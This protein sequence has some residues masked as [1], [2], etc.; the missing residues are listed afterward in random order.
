MKIFINCA[1]GLG[2]ITMFLPAY[3]A[4]RKKYPAANYTIA[5]DSRFYNDPF[6]KQ[7]FGKDCNIIKIYSKEEGYLKFLFSFIKLIRFRFDISI[8]AYNGNS[9]FNG[10]CL[11]LVGAKKT[12]YIQTTNK[13]LNRLFSSSLQIPAT[14]KH[15]I[16]INFLV[17]RELGVEIDVPEKWLLLENNRIIKGIN[18]DTILIGVHPGGNI[19]F[20]SARQW[21]KEY[22]KKLIEDLLSVYEAKIVI[23]GKGDLEDNMI[24]YIIGFNIDKCIKVIGCFLTEVSNLLSKCDIFIGNDS[25]LMNMAVALNVPTLCI[26]GPTDP[27]K[28]GPYGNKHSYIS[29]NLDCMPCFNEGYSKKCNHYNCLKRLY[30]EIVINKMIKYIEDNKII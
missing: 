2:N 6:F 17:T 18:D 1:T 29:L 8:A 3:R 23:F 21:P 9:I 16:E 11:L 28:T 22:Y 27:Q 13:L 15:Y 19:N 24:D 12:I 4:L 26:I 5:L 30:P 20:N 7:Q 10:I 25:S 14:T